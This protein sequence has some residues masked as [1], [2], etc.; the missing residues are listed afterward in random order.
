MPLNSYKRRKK[1]GIK[2]EKTFLNKKKKKHS[3]KIK[4]PN[5]SIAPYVM[6]FNNILSLCLTTGNIQKSIK[7]CSQNIHVYEAQT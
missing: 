5:R 6:K 3:G 4:C 2:G 1:D 7:D